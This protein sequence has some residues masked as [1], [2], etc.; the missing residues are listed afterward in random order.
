MS[1]QEHVFFDNGSVRVTNIALILRTGV[2]YPIASLTQITFAR[3]ASKRFW[4]S[5]MVFFGCL[6][7]IISWLTGSFEP[8][9][10]R[11]GV[12]LPIENPFPYQVA[13]AALLLLAVIRSIFQLIFPVYVV[14]LRGTFGSA[15]PIQSRNR[16]YIEKI[17]M[18]LQQ[19]VQQAAQRGGHAPVIIN[20]TLSNTNTPVFNNNLISG[21]FN[22]ARDI[23]VGNQAQVTRPPQPN[24]PFNTGMPGYPPTQ[25][26][27]SRPTNPFGR[28]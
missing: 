28:P 25:N 27:P 5:V 4:T 14:L 7:L 20:N 19:A 23:A 26:Y 21:A 18:A 16:Q 2:V 15:H 1:Q 8:T 10:V 3:I 24:A 17:A 9:L 13:G 22:D 12:V 6:L 11:E